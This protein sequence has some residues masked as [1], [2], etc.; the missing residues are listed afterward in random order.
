MVQT[1]VVKAMELSEVTYDGLKIFAQS[2]GVLGA[3]AFAVVEDALRCELYLVLTLDKPYKFQPR[4]DNIVKGLQALPSP[5]EVDWVLPLGRRLQMRFGWGDVCAP[6][7]AG[8]ALAPGEHEEIVLPGNLEVAAEPVFWQHPVRPLP[9]YVFDQQKMSDD[10]KLEWLLQEL[11]HHADLQEFAAKFIDLFGDKIKTE[12]QQKSIALKLFSKYSG[13]EWKKES[14]LTPDVLEQF[15]RIWHPDA[16]S[17]CRECGK[18]IRA[19]GSMRELYCDTVCKAAGF[20]LHCTRCEGAENYQPCT[21]C[22]P[23]PPWQ[24]RWGSVRDS[25]EELLKARRFWYTRRVKTGEPSYKLR[26]RS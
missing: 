7:G 12:S 15:Q 2:Q 3:G 8:Q 5:L 18:A 23:L 16:P 6:E 19:E 26:R 9:F 14:D 10:E 24:E 21:L 13:C 25:G 17:R 4:K 11:G 20:T 1:F 22:M